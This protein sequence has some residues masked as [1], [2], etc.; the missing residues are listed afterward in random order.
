MKKHKK[1]LNGSQSVDPAKEAVAN[2]IMEK[3]RLTQNVTAGG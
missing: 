3:V 2:R 1:N